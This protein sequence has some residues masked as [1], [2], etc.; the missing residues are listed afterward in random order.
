MT[1]KRVLQVA[2][3]APEFPHDLPDIP[4]Q[5]RQLFRPK[6]YQNDH[7]NYDQMWNAEHWG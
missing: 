3:R 6:Y 2:R 7:E 1:F 5:F 4:R